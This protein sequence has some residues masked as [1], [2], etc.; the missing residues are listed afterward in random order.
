MLGDLKRE[1][2]A[3]DRVV[4]SFA[5]S[6]ATVGLV[7]LF[8]NALAVVVDVAARASLDWPIDRLSDVSSVIFILCAACCLPAATARRRHVTIRA[9]DDRLPGIARS[10]LEALA[11]LLATLVFSVICWQVA[12]YAEE[13]RRTG[14]T[15]SQIEVPVWPLWYGVTFTLGLAALAQALVFLDHMM[16]VLHG[17]ESP[18]RGSDGEQG[19]T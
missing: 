14:Q 4:G 10:V 13:L 6:L 11:A 1:I 19:L 16:D 9:F 15:L 5:S 12:V 18:R 17:G 8:V 7:G 3:I 2:Q